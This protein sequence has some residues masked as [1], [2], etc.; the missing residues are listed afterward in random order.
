MA[1]AER[2]KPGQSL[3]LRIL[4]Q[5]NQARGGGSEWRVAE[6]VQQA[7]TLYGVTYKFNSANA[8]LR[9]PIAQRGLVQTR[10]GVRNSTLFSLTAEVGIA[11]R[12]CAI[13]RVCV[14]NTTA[15]CPLP[16]FGAQ[17]RR[18]AEMQAR[19]RAAAEVPA[20]Q[21]ALAAE[22]GAAQPVCACCDHTLVC[23]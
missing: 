10:K 19:Q 9:G 8:A 6:I 21:Q 23:V 14:T 13:A 3:V 12:H 2:P 18:V 5:P 16:P 17:G 22:G 15:L 20:P 11:A 7:A 1:M 4:L